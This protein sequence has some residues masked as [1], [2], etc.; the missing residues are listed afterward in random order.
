MRSEGGNVELR[1]SPTLTLCCNDVYYRCH[2]FI[3]HVRFEGLAVASSC[4]NEGEPSPT[5]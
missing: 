5:A 1:D 3:A 4:V 2:Y